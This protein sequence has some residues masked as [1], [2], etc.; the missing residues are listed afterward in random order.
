MK[1][2]FTNEEYRILVEML[3]IADWII[4]SHE[5]DPVEDTKSYTDLRK[6]VLSHYKEMGLENGFRYD[7]AADD[8]YETKDYEEHSA[9]TAF[10]DEYD[11]RKFWERLAIKMA[12]QTLAAEHA[13]NPADSDD[14]EKWAL[15][16][17]EL[18]EH[19]EDE[20]TQNG[21]NNVRIESTTGLH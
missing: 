7:P 6:K 18:A 2:N 17:F 15:R 3:L 8:Y 12:R 4:H 10:I 14:Q 20:F 19:F 16:L 11:E 9:H 13:V 5:G 1:I 21:L